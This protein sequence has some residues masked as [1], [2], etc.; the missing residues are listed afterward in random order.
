MA[1]GEY[2]TLVA[3]VKM[4]AQAILSE[5]LAFFYCATE[6]Y[7]RENYEL[8]TDEC[9][10]IILDSPSESSGQLTMDAGIRNM[11]QAPTSPRASLREAE[12]ATPIKI[13]TIA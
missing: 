1:L 7:L 11:Q 2:S 3:F 6:R 4:A 13:I 12:A 5:F 10:D 9:Y 8:V